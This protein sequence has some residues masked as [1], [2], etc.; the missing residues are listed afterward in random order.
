MATHT[1]KSGTK[2][3]FEYC[4][5][6]ERI[7]ARG[8][9]MSFPRWQIEQAAAIYVFANIEPPNFKKTRCDFCEPLQDDVV[10]VYFFP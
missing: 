7:K 4:P 8:E 10:G 9:W 5:Q 6:H 1:L 2:I 3:D